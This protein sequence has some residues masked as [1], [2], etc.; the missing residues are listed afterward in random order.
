MKIHLSRKVPDALGISGLIL[1]L[2]IA[3]GVSGWIL[4]VLVCLG[5]VAG[6]TALNGIRA[7]RAVAGSI[8]LGSILVLLLSTVVPTFRIGEASLVLLWLVMTIALYALPVRQPITTTSARHLVVPSLILSLV[9]ANFRLIT[10]ERA[11]GRLAGDF[12]EDNGAWLLA[13]SRSISG[14]ATVLSAASGASGGPS[15]GWALT[16]TRAISRHIDAISSSGIENNGVFLLRAYVL[17][18]MLACLILCIVVG[19]LVLNQSEVVRYLAPAVSA[20]VFVPFTLSLMKVGHFSALVAVLALVASFDLITQETSNRRERLILDTT[21]VIMLFSAGQAW[22]PLSGVAVLYTILLISD[23]ILRWWKRPERFERPWL[24]LLAAIGAVA[25]AFIV[26]RRILPTYFSNITDLDYLFDNLR[27]AGGYAPVNSMLAV[28]SFVG[29]LILVSTRWQGEKRLSFFLVS[30][31]AP[32]A[33][34]LVVSYSMH[35]NTPQYGTLKYMFIVSALCVPLA[36]AAA[37]LETA[38]FVPKGLASLLGLVILAVVAM[39]AP[40]A[41]EMKWLTNPGDRPNEWSSAVINEV[42]KGRTVVCLNTVKG[43]TGRDYEAYL[44]TRIASS[45][46]G[47]DSYETRTWT[48]ANICQIPLEQAKAAFT[49]AFQED[50]SVVLFDS[51]R[52]TSGAGCQTAS[53]SIIGGWTSVVDWNSTASFSVDGTPATLSAGDKEES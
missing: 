39:F 34:L 50:L 24:I 12:A 20:A 48:A 18:G 6:L 9:F 43:D 41:N 33:I 16:V 28:G 42:R 14:E 32:L 53:G 37:F 36:C 8:G 22:Y 21:G 44:C 40:P 3:L 38:R 17:V 4:L 52:S 27:L 45:L 49:P 11:L 19:R 25:L 15:T 46:A 7:L 5:L 31:L 29:C 51:S 35:P 47:A 23:F 1:A 13:L 26:V 30:L 2:S 10:P